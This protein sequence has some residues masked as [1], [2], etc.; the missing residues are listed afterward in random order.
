MQAGKNYKKVTTHGSQRG[1]GARRGRRFFCRSLG[2]GSKR[3]ILS[4]VSTTPLAGGTAS[5]T[6]WPRP[7]ARARLFL[8]RYLRC[9][10]LFL[11]RRPSASGAAE[12]P[13]R[14]CARVIRGVSL[15]DTGRGICHA[16]VV[17]RARL[18]DV[19]AE[20]RV[21]QRPSSPLPGVDR[22]GCL[23]LLLLTAARA[24]CSLF[25]LDPPPLQGGVAALFQGRGSASVAELWP[26]WCSA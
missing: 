6:S 13:V 3:L 1:R 4:R 18:C 21:R 23:L 24:A 12:S 19:R 10:I 25:Q 9:A 26:K 11:R 7:C 16:T 22:E 17:A 15:A 14:V 8:A 5:E 2:G 20:G